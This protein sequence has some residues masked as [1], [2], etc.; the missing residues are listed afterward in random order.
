M[1]RLLVSKLRSLRRESRRP[2]DEHKGCVYGYCFIF[3]P[4]HVGLAGKP[5]FIVQD[6]GPVRVQKR[7]LLK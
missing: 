5:V 3:A 7:I 2:D 6:E 4:F 1:F